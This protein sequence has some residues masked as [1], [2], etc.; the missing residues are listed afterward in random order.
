MPYITT[1]ERKILDPRIQELG[2]LLQHEGQLNYVFFQLALMYV[3]M[4]AWKYKIMN[5]VMGVFTCCSME[6]YRRKVVPYEETKIKEN[7]DIP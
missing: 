2:K 3:D 5:T 7:G 6:F 1:S 4:H